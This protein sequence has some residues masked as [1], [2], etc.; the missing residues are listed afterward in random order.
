MRFIE[1]TQHTKRHPC[2]KS[3][4]VITWEFLFLSFDN[5]SFGA[6]VLGDSL[7]AFRHGVLG[8]LPGQQQPH[9]GLHLPAGDGGALIVLSQPGRL[10]GN[11]LKQVIDEGVHD[12]HGPAG[13]PRV[14]MNLWKQTRGSSVSSRHVIAKPLVVVAS[15]HSPVSKLYRCTWRKFLF[16]WFFFSPFSHSN[17]FPSFWI[18]RWT[19]WQ[20]C[21]ETI[22]LL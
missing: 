17:F 21:N 15:L 7:G 19:F 9:R 12:A 18:H 22:S 8:Q 4:F 1:I 14:R 11:P 5:S 10:G 2:T 6:G 16:A 13:N 20:R 3:P